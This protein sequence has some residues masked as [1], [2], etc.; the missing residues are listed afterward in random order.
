MR[1][2]KLSDEEVM[3]EVEGR[4]RNKGENDDPKIGF[5]TNHCD[6]NKNTSDHCPDNHGMSLRA[7]HG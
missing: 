1:N 6:R 3:D 5:V 4:M 7:Y 2:P